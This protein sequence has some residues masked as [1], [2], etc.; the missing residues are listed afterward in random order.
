MLMKEKLLVTLRC[1]T[2]FEPNSNTR[3]HFYTPFPQK[4]PLDLGDHFFIL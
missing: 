3:I 4:H 2:W 1:C